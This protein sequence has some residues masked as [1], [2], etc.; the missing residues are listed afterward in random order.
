[1][2]F[3]WARDPSVPVNLEGTGLVPGDVYEIRDAQNFLGEPVV[4][5]VYAGK[6]VTIP[7]LSTGLARPVGNVDYP[8]EH[9]DREFGVFIVRKVPAPREVFTTFVEAENVFATD[10]V[11]ITPDGSS[12][13]FAADRPG[14][15]A[16]YMDVPEDGHYAAWFRLVPGSDTASLIAS[17]DDAAGDVFTVSGSSAWQWLTLNGLGGDSTVRLSPR[18]LRLTRGPHLMILRPHQQHL[19]LDAI[20][21]TNDLSYL[22]ATQ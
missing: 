19:S 12:L 21:I 6:P 18:L 22:P 14:L 15:A 3:N 8:P 1:V 9:T 17:V 16:L 5:G 20:V 7:M 2:V 11:A 13:L 4:S 10:G